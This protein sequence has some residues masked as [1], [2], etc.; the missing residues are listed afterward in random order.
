MEGS[1]GWRVMAAEVEMR[2]TFVQR[3]AGKRECGGVSLCETVPRRLWAWRALLF[4][5][6]RSGRGSDKRGWAHAVARIQGAAVH[7]PA[8]HAVVWVRALV[9]KMLE[10]VKHGGWWV[11]GGGGEEEGCGGAETS[12]DCGFGKLALGAKNSRGLCFCFVLK[13]IFK[14]AT[15]ATRLSSRVRPG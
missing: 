11:D 4:A 1:V 10:C 12:G 2:V 5:V 3:S 15:T 14:T 8:A 9:H 13:F 7:R 6:C